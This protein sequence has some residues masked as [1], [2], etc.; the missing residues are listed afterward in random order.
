MRS[1]F[2]SL[3]LTANLLFSG[4]VL[5]AGIT[6][7]APF[8]TADY[9]VEHNPEGD[10]VLLNVAQLAEY[11]AKLRAASPSIVDLANFP[12]TLQGDWVKARICDFTALNDQ[13]YLNGKAVS[14]NYKNI[15]RG[16]CNAGNI[17]LVVNTK[18]GVVV[19]R[20]SVR[21]LPTAQPLYFYPNDTD[22]D[23]LQETML[24]P[25]EPVAVLHTSDNGFLY[26]VQAGNYYGWVTKYNIAL[27]SK[28]E[29]LQYAQPQQFV[30]VTDEHVNLTA[31]KE[32][33]FCQMGCKLPYVGK[34][35]EGYLV[36]MPGRD[37]N[38]KLITEQVLVKTG[39]YDGYLPYTENNILRQ[40][41]KFNGKPYGW[42]GLKDSV[43]NSGLINTV[44]RTMGVHLPRN[45]DEQ[46]ATYGT[47]YDFSGL[48][49]QAKVTS[50]CKLKPGSAL[51]MDNHCGLYLGKSAEVPFVIHALGFYY[52]DGTRQKIM[53]VVVS[54]LSLQRA[55]GKTF[56]DELTQAV[57]YH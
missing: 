42:G 35:P 21:T 36:L 11:N 31:F 29:M 41:M 20:T 53:Q 23:A 57:Q 4:T 55:N 14:D 17:P 10:Q 45:G 1:F 37:K 52:K 19:R 28:A 50:L 39:V 56:L 40:V 2:L 26:F 34:Q 9:W 30:V 8:M 3:L 24:E 12:D 7:Y 33:I 22:F 48:N 44:Y 18:F 16:Q 25:G 27:C 43:D 6:H 47:H 5:A 49:T 54:D 38:D 32:D 51:F 13:L 15:L 46:A